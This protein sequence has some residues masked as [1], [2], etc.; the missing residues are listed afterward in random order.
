MTIV[1]NNVQIEPR[2][3]TVNSGSTERRLVDIYLDIASC[4]NADTI[5][6]T[7]YVPGLSGVAGVVYDCSTTGMLAVIASVATWS[8]T[9][10]TLNSG[11]AQFIKLEGY[12]S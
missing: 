11:V 2:A 12:Y 8:G 7:T 1:F 4:A 9:T 3:T 6:L 5:A 10:V